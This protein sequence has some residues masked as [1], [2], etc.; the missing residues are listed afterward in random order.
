MRPALWRLRAA[1]T[2]PPRFAP[3]STSSPAIS[4]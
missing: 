4:D 2:C 1:D 3:S